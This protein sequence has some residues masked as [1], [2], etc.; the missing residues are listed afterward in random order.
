M[1]HIVPLDTT[2]QHHLKRLNVAWLEKYFYVEPNDIVQLSEPQ[3]EIIDKGGY[4]FFATY[5]NKTVG[6]VSLLK[7]DNETYELSKMA[8]DNDFQGLG[9]GRQLMHHALTHAE[10][11]RAKKL[12]LFTNTKLKSAISLYT[13]FGFKPVPVLK[14]S[15]ARSNYKMELYLKKNRDDL[16]G[17]P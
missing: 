2:N 3:K 9:I 13:K 11:L 7:V 17:H 4:T 8:V 6:T 1:L 5:Q 14:S 12:I 15:Y 16:K 10:I